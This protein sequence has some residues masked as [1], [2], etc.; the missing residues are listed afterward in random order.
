MSCDII[1]EQKTKSSRYLEHFITRSKCAA[2]L[3]LLQVFPNCKEITEAW[4]A[5]EATHK[6]P[7][8][9]IDWSNPDIH[10]VVIGDGAT[11]RLGATIAFRSKWK[12]SSVD[13]TLNNKNWENKVQRLKC[14]RCK[15]ED[16]PDNYFDDDYLITFAM[17]S[18][19]PLSLCLPKINARRGLVIVACECCINLSL[20][21]IPPN[22]EYHDE[23]MWTP[24]NHIK[25]WISPIK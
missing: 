13:P 16:L 19:V 9:F 8:P 25:I 15:I 11:P 14:Y 21:N 1:V 4:G 23:H 10:A 20:A 6:L 2:D 18:H 7:K 3:L 24:K 12:V 5:F 22:I 17:H